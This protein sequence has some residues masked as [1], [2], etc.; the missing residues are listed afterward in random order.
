MSHA[1]LAVDAQSGLP[2]QTDAVLDFVHGL[3]WADLDAGVRHS[4]K[5]HLL[6]TV[7]VM[8]AGAVGNVA[9][10]AEQAL[11]AVRPEG[12][13]PVIGRRRRAD[14]LDAAYL[15]G[16]AAHGIELDD[17]YRQGSFH[18]GAVVIPAVLP[19]AHQARSSGTALL[20]A[21]VA[22]YEVCL[23]IAR[24]AHPAL[25]NRGFHPTAASGPFGAVVGAGKLRGLSPVHLRNAFGM[26]ASSSG[27]LFAFLN[28][29]ADIKRLHAGHAAREGLMAALLAEQGLEGPPNV[30]ECSD[31]FMQAFAY[32]PGKQAKLVEVPPAVPFAITDCY[33]KPYACCRHIQPAVEALI[34]LLN[35]EKIGE[36]QI[37]SV[38]VETYTIAAHHA[39]S[40]WED[41]ASAQ[42]SFPF[43]LAIAA[44]YRWIE[45][46][47][48]EDEVRQDPSIAAFCRDVHVAGTPDMDRRYPDNRPARVTVATTDG[49]RL[50]REVDEALGSRELPFDDTRLGQKFEGLVAPVL[51]AARAKDLL[52][53]LWDIEAN[54]DVAG[55]IEDAA[56]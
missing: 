32:S 52:A 11:A 38:D 30:I 13:V 48:F 18:P 28:G 12:T 6:D 2:G 8:I 53:R 46:R 45:V 3:R 1:A 23:A 27:G 50:T 29:G 35:E 47:H 10:G 54:P 20:E 55:L 9:T 19:L 42:L 43:L 56:Q 40:G 41:F 39:H 51:G 31:G 5:R 25:R 26:A 21:V 49:R 22:G 15:A 16:S 7:G 34:D 37:A 44:R 4:A 17:G 33:V 36:Q 24:A 14:I